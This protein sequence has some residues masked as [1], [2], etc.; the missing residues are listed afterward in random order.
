[1]LV[2]LGYFEMKNNES[3]AE[4][5][6]VIPAAFCDMIRKN[7]VVYINGERLLIKYKLACDYKMLG[8]V[9][10]KF[11]IENEKRQLIIP[12]GTRITG[13][14]YVK[15]LQDLPMV[16]LMDNVDEALAA[17]CIIVNFIA[18]LALFHNPPNTKAFQFLMK[19]KISAWATEFQKTFGK[20]F[21]TPYLH[22]LSNHNVEFLEKDDSHDVNA[23]NLQGVE[24]LND[25]IT[26]DFYRC[27]NKKNDTI[28]QMFRRRYRL[29]YLNVEKNDSL[30]CLLRNIHTAPSNV[31]FILYEDDVW[32]IPIVVNIL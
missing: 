3:R 11:E 1:M 23:Y 10:I 12:P 28:E 6:S 14:M 24:K 4:I 20:M 8:Q 18:L 31:D 22:V 9:K 27:T 26:T 7:R 30:N 29:L 2:P 13:E 17:Q 19:E 25:M 21:V 5:R 15:L 32:M 16:Q